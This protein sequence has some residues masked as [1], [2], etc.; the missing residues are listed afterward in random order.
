VSINEALRDRRFLLTGGPWR[1]LIYLLTTVPQA[2]VL[3]GTLA[4]IAVPWLKAV[5]DLRHGRLPNGVTLFFMVVAAGL[6]AVFAPLVAIP[7]GAVERA[8]LGIADPRPIATAHTPA[9]GD[10]VA[11]LRVRYAEGATWREVLYGCFL[12][13]IVPFAYGT[14]AL[15]ALIDVAFIVSP[16]AA[17]L[18]SPR[19]AHWQLATFEITGAWQS[20]PVGLL[21]LVLLPA[22]GYLIGLIA[23][24][25][26][27]T[28]RAL[29][30]LRSDADLREVAR[31]R[32]RLVD[33][34][35]AERRRI[36][37]DLHDGAQH[38]LTSL[39]LQ[40]GVARLDLPASSPAAEP[41]GKAHEQAKDLMVV[42]RELIHGIRPQTLTELGLPA[43]LREL[44][45]QSPVDV[46]VTVGDGVDRASQG[47]EETAYF[48]AAESLA[49][50]AR[51]GAANRVEMHLARD[52]EA[53]ILEIRDDG[54]GGADP[55]RG[56]GLTGLADRVAAV[57]G[58]LLLA[59]PAGGP[60]LVR[61]EL[62]WR[63]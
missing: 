3:G 54:L 61:V 35:D 5:D 33:A 6:F 22:L 58:R 46:A 13:V 18:V 50:A 36:E 8:R 26:A 10:P 16:F 53:L 21:G 25:Q 29:L 15:L 20:L 23:A 39:T 49:N 19:I 11:W 48:V 40:L 4:L 14:L 43:A 59:S 17:F 52:G 42:L 28:A 62:P 38:R 9:A 41:L 51:H 63:R 55:S 37:R 32:Q 45:A 24:G 34:F 27:A 7:L 47:A 56:S 44:A 12:S 30:G 2:A 31:S 57:G 1:S 60:T